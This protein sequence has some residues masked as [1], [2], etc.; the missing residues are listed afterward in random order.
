MGRFSLDQSM[1]QDIECE[2]NRMRFIRALGEPCLCF[3]I[4][5]GIEM[6]SGIL[7]PAAVTYRYKGQSCKVPISLNVWNDIMRYGYVNEENGNYLRGMVNQAM[8]E[9]S[10]SLPASFPHGRNAFLKYNPEPEQNPKETLS[11]ADVD[12]IERAFEIKTNALWE[13][14]KRNPVCSYVGDFTRMEDAQKELIRKLRR[15]AT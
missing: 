8:R 6:Y 9:I 13:Q 5:V 12:D 4:D 3:G 15:I 14:N 11:M 2:T 7:E 10:K 1:I